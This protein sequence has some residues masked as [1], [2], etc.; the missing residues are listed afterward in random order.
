[1]ANTPDQKSANQ[2]NSNSKNP[3]YKRHPELLGAGLILFSI[4]MLLSLITFQDKMPT[5]NLLG[6]FGYGAGFICL[7][8]FG[9]GSYPVMLASFWLGA[10]LLFAYVFRLK[11]L[12]AA[13]FAAFSFCL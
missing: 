2:K 8:I 5:R 3:W 7:K 9:I 1:M 13:S 4:A 6:L 10:R 12:F 11:K